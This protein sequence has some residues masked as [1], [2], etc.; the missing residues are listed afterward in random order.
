MMYLIA[1][2][3]LSSLYLLTQ[4]GV[5]ATLRGEGDVNFSYVVLERGSRRRMGGNG[6]GFALWRGGSVYV[7]CA[8][9]GEEGDTDHGG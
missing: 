2:P 1:L 9:R 5:M 8:R 7:S 4:S 3:S 6:P